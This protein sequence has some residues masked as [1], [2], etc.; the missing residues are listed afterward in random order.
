MDEGE[1]RLAA[2]MFTDVAG[3]T[4]MS[5]KDEKAT[6]DLLE[7]HRLLIRPFFPKHG[8]IEVKTMGD[9][10]L[11]EFPS[12][13]EAVRCALDI[14]QSLHEFNS[15]RPEP[16]KIRIR[17]GVH[18]G[19]VV[20]RQGDV[21]G[22][23][24]NLA[25]RIEPL[26]PPGGICLTRQVYDQIRNKFEF[27]LSNL[28]RKELKNVPE[29]IE[30]FRV[31]APWE[32]SEEDKTGVSD[33]KIAVLPFANM[34]PDPNDEYFADGMTEEV[35]STVSKLE[36]VEVISRTSVMQYKKSPKPMKDISREL[37][38]GTIL[39]G[40]VRK[41]GNK[42]RVTVQMIDAGRDRHVWAESYDRDFQ[43]VFAIQS[44]IATRVADALRVKF[45]KAVDPNLRPTDNIEAYNLWL[46]GRF[47]TSK[48]SKDSLM[49]GVEH[50]E[51]AVALA[52]DFGACYA[53]LAQA[54][55]MLGY[56][57]LLP[58]AE[59]LAKAKEY[60][61]RAL[62]LDDSLAE[63]HVAMGR[64]MRLYDWKFQ[65]ADVEL[66]RAVELAPNLATAHVFR[67]QGLQVLGRF[68]E[69]IEEAKKAL[70]LDPLS[71]TVCQILGTIYL[72]GGRYDDAIE[73]YKR[74]LELDP[75]SPFPL[76][77]LGL[78]YVQKGMF[79]EGI[80]L[81][82]KALK[83]EPSN[84]ASKNDLA[85]AY[86]KAGRKEEAI[87][88]LSDLLESRTP[89]MRNEAAVAG[90]YTSLGDHDKA[91]EWL[92]KA[93][94]AHTPYISSVSGDFIYDPLRSDPR[95]RMLVERI[96]LDFSYYESSRQK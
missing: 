37:E 82:E 9:A 36:N 17:I 70:E 95:F 58:P 60:A 69:A 5:Q 94:S 28:G 63:G 25:S 62:V 71:V 90:I 26:A 12:A 23:A 2:I 10:F 86:V 50:Y 42:L 48:L 84:A 39:E 27:P 55:L 92:D 49:K 72:Y 22:D 35:I 4:M 89:G 13:L 7:K 67:A 20:H 68:E 33:R 38:V 91:L 74:A 80:P 11:V 40:S 30:V 57:E 85:Y 53:G 52:P 75:A 87:K 56:F 15:S 18:L 64:I 78:T 29:P 51:R 54:W 93:V 47:A 88:I 45:S 31:V 41:A 65:E 73:M 8:G 59:A 83:L 19:D 32:K 16:E 96:G 66:K 46:K 77:N 81:L 3:Y 24:V 1:R 6:L 76:G 61:K 44:D 34:S 21:Y 79:E 43:D 14:Q